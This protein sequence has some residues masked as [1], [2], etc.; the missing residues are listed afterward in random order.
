VIDPR[1]S[2]VVYVAAY[3]PLWSAGGDRGSYKT[4]DGGANWTKI[5]NISENTGISDV[6]MDPNNP[7]VLIADRA[8][9]PRHTWTLIHGGPGERHSTSPPMAARRGAASARDS[10]RRSRPH[11]AR[12]LAGAERD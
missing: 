10:Q 1:D 7:D 2:K 11:R 3:G 5:L 6:A 9:A 8:S 4:T 12:V